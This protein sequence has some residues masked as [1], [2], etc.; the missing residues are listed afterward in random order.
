MH[1]RTCLRLKIGFHCYTCAPNLASLKTRLTV[2]SNNNL[3]VSYWSCPRCSS[4]STFNNDHVL[5]WNSTPI[6]FIILRLSANTFR[7]SCVIFVLNRER[8]LTLIWYLLH[9]NAN[10]KTWSDNLHDSQL[11]TGWDGSWINPTVKVCL[12]HGYTL[13]IRLPMHI[14]AKLLFCF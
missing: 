11:V 3:F 8:I 14:I 1:A 2:L 12:C 5:Q 10:F 4:K 13:E 9:F 7:S 6:I